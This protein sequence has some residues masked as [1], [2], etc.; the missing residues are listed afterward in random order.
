MHVDFGSRLN[1]LF[2]EMCQMNTRIGRIA[3]RQSRLGGFAPSPS[4]DPS[5]ESSNNG[6][7]ESDDASGSTNDDEMTGFKC[8]LT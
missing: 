5:K 7:D 4:P 3:R 2:D 6:D 8:N 1:H